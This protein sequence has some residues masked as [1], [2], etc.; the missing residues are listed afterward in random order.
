MAK[1]QEEEP[2]EDVDLEENTSDEEEEDE[3]DG[4]ESDEDS[5]DDESED[6]DDDDKK[7]LT[8]A[9]V[10]KMI[11]DARN[12]DRRRASKKGK[13]G[14]PLPAARSGKPDGRVD[15]I[16]KTVRS[17]QETERKRQFGYDNDLAPKEVDLVFRL[18]KRPTAKVLKDPAVKGAIDGLRAE[19]SA[20][21]NIPGTT[22][23]TFAVGGKK[24]NELS[25]DDK[26]KHFQDRRK[27]EL[28]K[29]GRA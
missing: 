26:Q 14:K 19:Q 1:D 27:A 9:E 4:D 6:E 17:L 24:F 16:D 10:Q 25:A 23:R 2:T 3:D 22:G 8:K 5:E 28:Q 15:Q 11:S 21:D 20:K 7:P 18:Y 29:Q 12:A 13:D